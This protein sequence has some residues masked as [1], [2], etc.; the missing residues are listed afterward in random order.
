MPTSSAVTEYLAARTDPYPPLFIR[1]NH[2]GEAGANGER[3]RMGKQTAWLIVE[4]YS[5]E[6]GIPATPQAFPHAMATAMLINGAGL[7]L[8]Q[9]L[10]ATQTRASPRRCT[11]STSSRR[12]ERGP[13]RSVRRWPSRLRRSKQSRSGAA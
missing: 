9:D 13:T 3:W 6:T 5:R 11:R 4:R 1:D 10:P 12:C 7:S 8:M 2:R